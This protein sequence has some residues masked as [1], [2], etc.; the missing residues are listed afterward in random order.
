MTARRLMIL[1]LMFLGLAAY[2]YFFEVQ[3]EKRRQAKKERQQQLIQID[4]AKITGLCFLPANIKAQRINSHWQIQS[5]VV[6]DADSLT[7][8]TI[9]DGLRWMKK[10]RFVSDN[11]QDWGK[12][13]LDPYQFAMVIQQGDRID[14][15]FIGDS[16]LDGSECYY[17]SHGSH[18]VFLVPISLRNSASK[19]LFDLRD[20]SILKFEP[21]NI[22]AVAITNRGKNF[23][24][25]REERWRWWITQPISALAD[26]DRLDA[27]LNQI[28]DGKV[29]GVVSETSDGLDRYGLDRPWLSISLYDSARHPVGRLEVGDQQQGHYHAR[30]IS[31]PAIVLIDS[32]LVAQLNVSL[33]NLRDKTIAS[34]DPDSVTGIWLE[35]PGL[36]FHCRKDS[37]GRWVMHQPDSALVRSWKINSLLYRIKDLKVAQFIEPPYRSD[38]YYGFDRPEIRVK[39]MKDERVVTDLVLGKAIE[40]KVYLKSQLTNSVQLVKGQ[41]KRELSIETAD[42][43]D[44]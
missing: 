13:G 16:N 31:Q 5:P 17:R 34:F 21:K 15:L 44:K 12:F 3:G 43:I 38:R 2:V 18:Q 29:K 7:M 6:T 30:N 10:G 23:E 11:P 26:E 14:S 8:A 42:F 37:S 41:A 4:V 1:L 25:R 27:M 20:K 22:A 32:S 35:R 24:C 33:Y 9:L 36:T 40:D 19:S 39:L 28:A